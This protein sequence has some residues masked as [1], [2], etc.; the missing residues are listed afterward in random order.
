MTFTLRPVAAAADYND[1]DVT[2]MTS[3]GVDLLTVD[4]DLINHV[5]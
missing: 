1:D 4:V 2:A 5:L 3:R